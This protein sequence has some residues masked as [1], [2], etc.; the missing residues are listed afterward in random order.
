MDTGGGHMTMHGL[1]GTTKS[2]WLVPFGTPLSNKGLQT[3]IIKT[4][5]LTMKTKEVATFRQTYKNYDKQCHF[6]GLKLAVMYDEKDTVKQYGAKW[7]NDAKI[8]W[9]PVDRITQDVHASVGTVRDWLNDH[10]MIVGQYGKFNENDYTLNLFHSG[11]NHEYT[12]YVLQKSEKDF[13]FTV[14]F[15]YNQDV[16][17]FIPTGGAMTGD[18]LLLDPE[19]YTIEDGRKRWDVLIGV[20]Y[21]RKALTNTGDML[22]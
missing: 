4:E 10:K 1:R 8:W 15:F 5:L 12:E 2:I 21:E 9:M 3:T 19:Y 22:Q 11:N 16:A 18:G 6:E 14:Q 20:G 7:D 17:K 13:D